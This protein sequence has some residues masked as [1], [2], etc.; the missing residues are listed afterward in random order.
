M[1]LFEILGRILDDR[2]LI[3]L[4]A[5]RVEET[6]IA[7]GGLRLIFGGRGLTGL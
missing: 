6:S 5:A 2:G 3:D 7:R 1:V 4:V